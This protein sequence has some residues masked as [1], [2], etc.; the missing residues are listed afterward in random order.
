MHRIFAHIWVAR[1]YD[2]Q[3]LACWSDTENR[4]GIAMKPKSLLLALTLAI[5]SAAHAEGD[6]KGP[7]LAYDA[8]LATRLGADEYGMRH[9]VLV[10][11]KTGPNKVAKGPER[12]ALFKGHMANIQR[13]ADEGQLAV[14]GPF[15]NESDGK[16]D[17]RGLF[18]FAVADIEAAKAL[19]ATDPTIVQGVMVAEYHEL[20]CSAALML[21]NDGHHHV[22]KQS[23]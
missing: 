8:A 16:G 1:C 22:A 9:Y 12:D 21:V 18:I 14:A 15:E 13:L 3:S 19:V 11:L 4:W 17:W 7:V 20:Y 6:K 23:F 10:I 5:C 2:S